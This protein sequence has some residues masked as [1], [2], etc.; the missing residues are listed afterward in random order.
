MQIHVKRIMIKHSIQLIILTV[1]Y[2]RIEIYRI[3]AILFLL[4]SYRYMYTCNDIQK[5][6]NYN[7]VL[8]Q[9]AFQGYLKTL[10]TYSPE[11]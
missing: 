9:Y 10:K 7:I 6:H 8:I 1:I 5:I 2:L 3:K 11:N 4:L